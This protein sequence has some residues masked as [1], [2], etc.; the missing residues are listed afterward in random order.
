MCIILL[1]LADPTS[2]ACK[3]YNVLCFHNQ[4]PGECRARTSIDVAYDGFN[5]CCFAIAST[6]SNI[7]ID[8]ET[9]CIEC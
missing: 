4:Q 9:D 6:V 2:T 1:I 5:F 8:G 7:R 3:H